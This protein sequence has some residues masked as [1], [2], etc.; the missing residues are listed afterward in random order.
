MN[1]SV[2]QDK[3]GREG[4]QVFWCD[5]GCLFQDASGRK[6]EAYGSFSDGTTVRRF[7]FPNLNTSNESEYQTLIELLS[8]LPSGS[9]PVVHTDSKLLRGQLV[10]GWRVKTENL[11]PLHKRARELMRSTRASLTWVPR[12]EVFA[13]LG[14]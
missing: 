1:K 11:K 9:A 4:S 14:H 7:T 13:K 5:G 8:T 10:R 3:A 2:A 12:T 6:R